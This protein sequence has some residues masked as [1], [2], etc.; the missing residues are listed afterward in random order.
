[1][2]RLLITDRGEPLQ[3]QETSANRLGIGGQGRVFSARLGSDLVAVKLLRQCEPQRLQDL[4][5]LPA[6][7]AAAAT[8]PIRLLHEAGERPGPVVGYAMRR[9]DP[10]ASLQATRLFNFQEIR[11]LPSFTWREAIEAA[12]ALAESVATLHRHGVVIGDLNSE[13]V[14]F[15]RHDG[16]TAVVMDSDSFQLQGASGQ[17]H[18]C[19]VAR[20]PYTAPELVGADLRRT[21]RQPASDGFALAVLIHQLLLHD[22]PYDNAINSAD[23]DLPT[24]ARI[25]RGLYPHAAIAHEG[26][27]ASPFRP[28]PAALGPAIERAFRRSFH[29]T[30]AVP[31]AGLRPTASAWAALLRTLLSEVVPC[32]RNR[33]HHHRRG[34][35]CLW[36]AVD[37][38]AGHGI[39]VFPV[40]EVPLITVAPID[41]ILPPLPEALGCLLRTLQEHQQHCTHLRD[42][43]ASLIDQ[44]FELL[45]RSARL[46]ALTA[47]PTT[48][49]N[50][51]AL[52]QR[53][54]GRNAWWKRMLRESGR[55]TQR[56]ALLDQLLHLR[57]E[58]VAQVRTSLHPQTA[59]CKR[60]LQRLSELDL[61]PVDRSPLALGTLDPGSP[62]LRGA[63]DPETLLRQQLARQRE[64]ALQEQLPRI[65][66]R[67]LRVEGFGEGRWALLENQGLVHLG[68]LHQRRNQLTTLSGI[69]PGLA[70]RLRAQL[71]RVIQ[72]QLDLLAPQPLVCDPADLMPSPAD[73]A[74][75]ERLEQALLALSRELMDLEPSLSALERTV[76]GQLAERDRLLKAF[77][78][79]FR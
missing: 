11:R 63:A 45:R 69:G 56:Q 41:Q 37:R 7:C 57:E 65:P 67:S 44:L 31:L 13:N 70:T 66:L 36:C 1:M 78:T 19:P 16:W 27:S 48:L 32:S 39:S 30:Q 5:A 47:N 8:L 20:A 23:P 6:A 2:A 54:D 46:Q 79:L 40:K 28:S 64:Q 49:L 73:R 3:L 43:Q 51:E 77:E 55:G 35:T 68:H 72:D 60:L 29:G 26:L 33:Q 62:A 75:L 15:Q 59:H 42:L 58:L 12:I 24:S 74:Q 61:S 52:Q 18:P 38:Q 17:R 4:Q 50:A 34:Q 9:L 25:A 21:W 71:D 14:L 10:A 53:I 76:S 22:H